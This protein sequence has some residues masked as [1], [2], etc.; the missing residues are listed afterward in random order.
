M[1]EIIFYIYFLSFLTLTITLKPSVNL[2]YEMR[3]FN[4][5]FFKLHYIIL[6]LL[7][8]KIKKINI[9]NLK[10][11]PKNFKHLKT[12]IFIGSIISLIPLILNINILF[13]FKEIKLNELTWC[14]IYNFI[15]VGFVEEFIF[16]GFFQNF[17]NRICKNRFLALLLGAFLFAFAHIPASIIL[18]EN[19][20]L[21]LTL[22]T[23]GLMFMHLVFYFLK[24]LSKDLL[25]STILH[26]VIDVLESLKYM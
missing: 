11:K 22:Y 19:T 9:K 6:I 21:S 17:S 26:G 23:L 20:L 5:I 8:L 15:I 2:N 7:I 14:F 16:R 18:Q 24:F 12:S 10:L 3:V 25:S 4:E 13:K 1:L